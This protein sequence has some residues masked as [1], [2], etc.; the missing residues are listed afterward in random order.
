MKHLKYFENK[1]TNNPKYK[2]G[3]YVYTNHPDTD[4]LSVMIIDDIVSWEHDVNRWLNQYEG[5][6]ADYPLDEDGEI[7]KIFVMEYGI[8]RKLT[9]EEIKEHEIEQAAKKYNI[10]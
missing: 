3:D 5:T 2:I 10:L 6:M 4:K 7:N 8:D 9:P 1:I